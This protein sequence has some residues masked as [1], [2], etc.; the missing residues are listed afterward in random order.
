M[1]SLS[2]FLTTLGVVAGLGAS[3]VPLASYAADPVSDGKNIGLTATVGPVIS[4][5][6]DEA[7]DQSGDASYAEGALDLGT[8]NPNSAVATGAVKVSV[9]TNSSSGYQ[10]SISAGEGGNALKSGDDSI[11]AG[12]P[13]RGQSAWGYAVDATGSN[14]D[15]KSLPGSGSTSIKSTS[16]YKA[17]ADDT[18]VTFG[19]TAS[20]SQPSGE[21]TGSVVFTATVGQ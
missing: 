2:K 14:Y 6:I 12:T 19:V 10:L 4:I 21:Y 1:T 20:N 15:W 9:A 18:V 11:P 8:I 16:S 7:D 3:M 17:A 5:T 13:T